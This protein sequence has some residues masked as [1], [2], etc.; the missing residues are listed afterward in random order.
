MASAC[1]K[2]CR[3]V[4]P[5]ITVA[6]QVKLQT[7]NAHLHSVQGAQHEVE[8]ADRV[9]QAVRQLLDH[10]RKAVRRRRRA[11][12]RTIWV[13]KWSSS[14]LRARCCIATAKLQAAQESGSKGNARQQATLPHSGCAACRWQCW[15]A[16]AAHSCWCLHV[17]QP[18]AEAAVP[19][20]PSPTAVHPSAPARHS[21]QHVVAERQSRLLRQ[22]FGAAGRQ[23][24]GHLGAGR[25]GSKAGELWRRRQRRRAALWGGGR[26]AGDLFAHN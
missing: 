3:P 13:N 22:L 1:S 25:R 18:N 10:H 7:I 6:A 21:V 2:R 24:H 9:P 20:Q 5:R 23:S 15:L 11:G 12:S 16:L 19:K 4:L 26:L 14:A 8:H 17:H